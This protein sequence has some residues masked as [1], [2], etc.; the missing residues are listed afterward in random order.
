MKEQFKLRLVVLVKRLWKSRMGPHRQ[1]LSVQYIISIINIMI[2][3]IFGKIE[4]GFG[5]C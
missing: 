5:L 4:R 3:D 1:V 2:G